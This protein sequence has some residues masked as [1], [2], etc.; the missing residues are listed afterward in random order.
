MNIALQMLLKALSGAEDETMDLRRAR[1]IAEWKKLD[2]FRRFYRTLDYK[3]YNGDAEVPMRIYFPGGEAFGAADLGESRE[4][5]AG[6]DFGK[7]TD[8]T[9]PVLLFFHGGGF[10]TE[11][12]ETYN[13]ICWDMARQTG[14]VVVSVD[15][16]LAPEYRF[17]VPFEDCYAAARA[18]FS[19]ESILNVKP[20]QIT[21]IGDSAGGNLAAA[22]C[23]RARDTGDFAPKRQILIYP[24]LNNDYSEEVPYPSVR[25]NGTGYL[26]TRKNMADYLDLYEQSAADRESPYFSPLQ[27][28][29]YS[30]LPDALV[31][32]GQ[33]DPLRDEGEEYAR[34]LRAAGVPVR[35]HRIADAVHGFFLL[36]VGYP[37][38]KETYE[39]INRFLR[40]KERAEL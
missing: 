32:T 39:Y 15:Y 11:S 18:I 34:R 5:R 36:P 20:E 2:P 21:I 4:K 7:M 24:C 26:L 30:N 13:R 1:H 22:V 25:E 33:Y 37:A 3:I 17:P 9:Y 38:V 35:L 28:E 29:D 8:N 14:Q 12:M 40:E 27:A 10:V 6:V 16:R 23:Q 31:I 19:N